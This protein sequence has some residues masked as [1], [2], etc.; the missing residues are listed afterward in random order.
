MPFDQDDFED[1]IRAHLEIAKAER[2]AD[3][4]TF[5][6]AHQQARK[7]FGNITL[8]TEAARR[9][10]TPWW[11]DALHDRVSD[12]R[13]A[14]RSLTKTPAF[15]LTVVGALALGIGVNAG[16]F[17]MLKAAAVSPIA[18]V[19]RSASLVTVFRETTSGRAL[20]V[21]YPE[22]QYLRDHDTA[23]S[24][25]M[26]SV[27]A[28]VGLGRG[29]DSR[30]LFAE[31]V[32]G[33]YFE[34]LGVR[35]ARGRTLLP[36][37]ESAPG[38]QPVV[39]LSDGLWRRDFGADPAIV[40]TIITVNNQPLTVAG[41]TDPAFHGTSVVYDV[42]L[43]VPITMAPA[44]GFTFNSREST[45]ST[46][47]ADRQ[48]GVFM[49]Q[50][51]LRPGTTLARATAQTEALGAVLARE[52][53]ISESPARMR[54]V[55]FWKTPGGAPAVLLPTLGL[56]SAMGLLV[57]TIAC[58]NIAGLVLVRG[59]SRRGEIAVRLAIGGA[60]TRIV[61]L[62]VVENVVVALPA[63]ALGLLLAAYGIPLVIAWV[64]RLAAPQRIFLNMQVDGL[65]MTFAVLVACGSAI[66]FG[67][68]P[69]LQSSR[70]D[71]AAVMNEVSPRGATPGRLRA[72]LVVAQVAVSLLLLVGSGLVARSLDA[73]R[74]ANPGFEMKHLATVSVD[75]KQ[76]GYDE[77]RGRLFYRR[78]LDTVR[79]DPG[80]SSATVAAYAPLA[81]VDQ[82]SRHIAI[83]GYEP[84]R[85]QDLAFLWNMVGP[86][87][88]RTLRIDLAVGRDF[89]DRDDET[90]ARVAIVNRTLAERFWGAAANAIGR[91][92][93]LDGEDW[94]TV[95][96]V[97]ADV[98]YIR[99][100]EAPRPYVYVPFLQAYRPAMMLQTR[101]PAPSDVLVERARA[102]ITALDGELPILSARPDEDRMDGALMLFTL[103]ARMLS[104]FGVTGMALAAL[105]TY[106]LVAYTVKQST[107]EIGI[108]MALGASRSNVVRA[109]VGRGLRLGGLGAA[110]G[111]VAALALTRLLATALFGVSAT[112]AR[113]FGTAL[114]IVLGGVMVATVVP[115][116][117]AARTNPLSA[118]RH[119]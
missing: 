12:V 66:V 8:T 31:F 5:R 17:T 106:G 4:A 89:A 50:G 104:V 14:I 110:I 80:T 7:E 86:D 85:D 71:L 54:T 2:V 72:A 38:R 96:G 23:F 39:V 118:L 49:P 99:I 64:E 9:Q 24:G 88:F 34:V 90:A 22:F 35:A 100:N 107:H 25:L 3:G 93:R 67:F 37:D 16:V 10:W 114:A 84:K 63:A 103:S 98:K 82:P 1:E 48:A 58:A 62:L 83:E 21:S 53:P 27:L 47:L 44:L 70:V 32:S 20:N 95:V 33:N 92:V 97:A 26:G 65:V 78:L 19:S 52:R 108:R 115:A 42:E 101:G 61:R 18:G 87:Y 6:D 55:A 56:L 81:F 28:K 102:H 46:I 94:R 119:Q 43:Y 117:R 13:Y 29:R 36:G 59:L 91:R 30:S 40:G 112:D 113:S 75:V 51:F 69:A 73:A 111:L 77:A 60:R 116:W 15:A 41:I 68:V 76:N 105:G 45:P 109:F 11:V 79:A 74:H 57:L